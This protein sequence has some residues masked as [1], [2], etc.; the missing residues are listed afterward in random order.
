VAGLE[1]VLIALKYSL[2]FLGAG[3]AAATLNGWSTFLLFLICV[4][5][6]FLGFRWFRT[7]ILWRLRNRLIVTYLFIGGVPVF[8]VMLMALIAGYF[9]SGQFATFLTVSE[10][11]SQLQELQDAN[12][13][14]AQQI[15]R[16]NKPREQQEV[17]TDE[18][19]FP[20]RTILILPEAS[21]PKWLKDGFKGLVMDQDQIC[22][23]AA[24]AVDAGGKHVWVI[25]SVPVDQKFLTKISADL[26][27]ITLYVSLTETN[28]V[29]ISGHGVTIN[30]KPTTGVSAGSLPE[31]QFRGDRAL[32]YYA[33]I[34]TTPW[35][36]GGMTTALMAGSV[37][38]STLYSRLSVSVNEW[39]NIV[40]I[41]LTALAATFGIIVLVALLIG[42]RLTRTITRS[43]ANLYKATEHIN[44]GDF[45][46]RIQV[47]ERDQLATLQVAF[48]SMTE[49]VEK[50]IVEQK[51]KERLQ[52]ELAIAQEVQAQLFPKPMS[53]ISTLELCGVCRPARI[54][55][56]DYYD[57]IPYGSE[58]IGIALGDISGKGIS[59]ALL[60]ATIHSAV[61]AYEQE[62]LAA[63]TAGHTSLQ[64]TRSGSVGLAIRHSP[65]Q[66]PSQVLWLLNRQL[67]KTTQPEKYAT[68]FL[69][70]YDGH[71]RRLTYSNAG[72]LPPLILGED[73]SLRRLEVGG[74][75][76]GLFDNVEYEEST[77][78]LYPE[79]IFIA[80]S[81]GITEPENE[82]G[83]FGEDRLIETIETHRNLPLARI[84]DQVIAAVQDWIG[85]SEQPDDITVVLAKARDSSRIS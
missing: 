19:V 29:A 46:H 26:G 83:E 37:R 4:L 23:R 49:S 55:S 69:G 84:A 64:T 79:D 33:L 68:L 67:Y 12:T 41:M 75:V 74:T 36:T 59:A 77:V 38:L 54:V 40:R 16:S 8:L 20:G 72:H 9:V 2:Q 35:K 48:N 17:K 28:N 60:M 42:I 73:R 43:V 61:R 22:L 56:G 25:S 58:Q 81:D 85:S 50:L 70:F 27:P 7:F 51:E 57:F 82:F 47:K 5:V 52:S 13:A 21:R 15:A 39:A 53:G 14:S 1:L 31:P 6:L 63:V 65:P 11:Q 44:R 18:T 32:N 10:I 76:V 62:Q 78:E 34:Q 80:F 24:T 30:G 71:A 45:T 3:Q 66:S